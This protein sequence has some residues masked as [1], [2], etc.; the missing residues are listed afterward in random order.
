MLT[1]NPQPRCFDAYQA[2]KEDCRSRIRDQFEGQGFGNETNATAR[3][4]KLGQAHICASRA[5]GCFAGFEK[6]ETHNQDV[7]QM[8]TPC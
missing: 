4:D 7:S 2:N 5:L 6:I 8:Q 3:L 1:S